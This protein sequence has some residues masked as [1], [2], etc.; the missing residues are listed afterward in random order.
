METSIRLQQTM[1][2]FKDIVILCFFTII[3][4][5]CF[6]PPQFPTTPEIAYKDIW[7]KDVPG[8]GT[9]DS[10]ILFITFK[11]GDGDLGLETTQTDAPHHPVN[12]FLEDGTGS[13][14]PIS[15]TSRN[16]GLLPFL[17]VNE[18]Q[19]GK[20]VSV[21]TRQKPA[22]SFLP[23]RRQFPCTSYSY[24]YDSVYVLEK[25]KGIFD[26]SYNMVKT[27]KKP[28][29]FVLVDSLYFEPNP[30][31]Y[32]IEID[33]LTLEGVGKP[34]ADAE[35]YVEYDW[36]KNFCLTF[37]GRFPPL[38]DKP[39]A[40]EGTLRYGMISSGFNAIFSIKT[41]KLRVQI[42]DRGLHLSNV[43]YTPPFKLEKIR[44]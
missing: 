38:S 40:L 10:L 37:D 29:G 18:N 15:T 43:I 31:H 12:Y 21:R 30:D 27:L 34:G 20:L 35:G 17:N 5:A 9:F 23:P 36:R 3:F 8:D 2:I 26:A 28:K 13:L 14:I 16:A 11:D 6:D 19:T 39:G 25:D 1:K 32:N 41:L 7:F 24:D 22:Y 33:F 44:R 4:N 42:K